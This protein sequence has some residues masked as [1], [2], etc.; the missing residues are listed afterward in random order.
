MSATLTILPLPEKKIFFAGPMQNNKFDV[1]V[2]SPAGTSNLY[3]NL[4]IHFFAAATPILRSFPAVNH[5]TYYAAQ[6]DVNEIFEGTWRDIITR[7]GI[8]TGHFNFPGD[9][10]FPLVDKSDWLLMLGFFNF[11]YSYSNG[12]GVMVED[13]LTDNAADPDH[14]FLVING[15]ATNVM[16]AWLLSQEITLADYFVNNKKFLTW[17]PASLSVHPRQPVKLYFFNPGTIQLRINVKIHY[18]DGSTRTSGIG[19]YN[20]GTLLEVMSG[21]P[22]LRLGNFDIAKT[23]F[24]YE[25]WLQDAPGEYIT[26]K[27]TFIP[28]YTFY[29]R[30]DIFLFRNSLGVFD[31]FWSHGQRSEKV[32]IE[33]SQSIHP[34]LEPSTRR[35]TIVQGRGSFYLN[36]ESNTGFFSKPDRSWLMEFLTCNQAYFPSGYVIHPVLINPGEFRLAEDRDDLFSVDYAWRVAHNERYHSAEPPVSSPFG[37]FND[38]FNTD[39]F[40]S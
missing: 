39:F 36:F 8:D 18:T 9:P 26:E 1:R 34:L 11:S 2:K 5:T 7:T 37:D 3:I 22:N 30:N 28:D 12:S 25:I 35:G 29:E 24:K 38:D 16:R 21:I 33:K 19:G 27:R 15:G 13:G 40:I 32:N 6:F 17:M 23:I 10:D 14:Q 31:V 20:D 4:Y